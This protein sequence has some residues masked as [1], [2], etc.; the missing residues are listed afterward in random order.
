[1]LRFTCTCRQ[2]SGKATIFLI[3]QLNNPSFAG[4]FSCGGGGTRTHDPL[5]ENAF[6]AFAIA[7]RRR[8]QVYNLHIVPE[9][10]LFVGITANRELMVEVELWVVWV[11]KFELVL[12]LSP[13]PLSADPATPVEYPKA[14]VRFYP[15]WPQYYFAHLQ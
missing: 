4:L 9:E 10:V 3:H 15:T 11:L 6:Q 1:M 12:A 13:F 8:L 7:T 5:R 14:R 2:E